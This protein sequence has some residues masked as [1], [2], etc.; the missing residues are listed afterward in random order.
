MLAI[1]VILNTGYP[2]ARPPQLLWPPMRFLGDH[3]D[4]GFLIHKKLQPAARW[5][6][7]QITRAKAHRVS[8]PSS[9]V[10]L[11]GTFSASAALVSFAAWVNQTGTRSE[12]PA[13]GMCP[14]P[15]GSG[16]AIPPLDT[17]R[18]HYQR[19]TEQN[20]VASTSRLSFTTVASGSLCRHRSK[21]LSAFLSQAL[22]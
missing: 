15:D 19:M 14:Q 20:V 10:N 5:P 17:R 3:S 21:N 4:A 1:P 6:Q 2:E 9:G 8:V 16:N 11:I 12:S 7:R 13:S 22:F 18:V